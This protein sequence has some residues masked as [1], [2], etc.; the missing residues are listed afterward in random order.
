MSNEPVSPSSHFPSER[1]AHPTPPTVLPTETTTA[2]PTKRSGKSSPA[3]SIDD[4]LVDETKIQIRALVQE[5]AELAQNE[6]ETEAFFAGFL[7]RTTAALASIGGAVWMLDNS[8]NAL[9]LVQQVNLKATGLVDQPEAQAQHHRLMQQT[10]SKEETAIVPPG[11]MSAQDIGNPTDNLLIIAPLKVSRA[12]VGLVEI[13]QRPGAGPK[14]QRGYLRFVQQMSDLASNFL[15]NQQ[16]QNFANQQQTWQQLEQFIRLVHQSLDLKQTA[17]TLA[18]E[19]RRLIECDR[20]SVALGETKCTVKAVS[21]LDA[22]ERRAEQIK[23]LSALATAC[24]KAGQPIWY[25]GETNQ[26]PPQIETRIQEYVDLS[27]ATMLGIVPLEKT[28]A[29]ISEQPTNGAG[30]NLGVLIVEQLSDSEIT[31]SLKNRTKIAV[32]HGQVAISNSREHNQI[33]LM[34]LWKWIGKL[35]SIFDPGNRI[36][37]VAVASVAIGV[38]LFLC[39]FPYS[40]G[41]SANGRLVPETKFEV[42]AQ[43]DGVIQKVFVSDTGDTVVKQGETLGTMKNS[44]IDLEITNLVGKIAEANTNIESARQ[45]RSAGNLDR[46]ELM[47]LQGEIAQNL[48]IVE[49]LTN[50]LKIRREDL[51]LLQV[52][53]P[54]NGRVV[55]WNA[56]QNLL[57]RPVKI[58]QNLM[59]IVPPSTVWQLELQMPEK[60]LTHLFD[61]MENQ[62]EPLRVTFGLLSNPGIEYEG[63]LLSVD[64]KLDVYSD[65]GNSALVRVAFDNGTIDEE[66]LLS[67]TRVTA[68]IHCGERSIGYVMFHE[69][70]ETV[71]SKLV[72]WF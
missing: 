23:K 46:D 64:Q 13:F 35:M 62:K 68:K 34:P 30:K 67:D 31:S 43:S 45:R 11:S 52:L 61:A 57:N 29:G 20:V 63:T 8:T 47:E 2:T 53:S 51:A 28:D 17:Y 72:F 48:Q 10:L 33:F 69:L 32:E 50:E 16:V 71:Q 14:T 22:I 5:I 1:L 25:D 70:I 66:L 26:L 37:T 55:T 42:F 3:P 65:D 41:L 18:N 58:G 44:D 15:V 60:R 9:K 49:S 36:K 40:F 56:R 24:L 38:A 4:Q 19:G 6:T 12:T 54:A 39:W 59:T 21:G 7:S 27:H